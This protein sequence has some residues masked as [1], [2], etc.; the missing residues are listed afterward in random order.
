MIVIVVPRTFYLRTTDYGLRYVPRK[1]CPD[2]DTHWIPPN[3]K[4]LKQSSQL[5]PRTD[6]LTP[7][8]VYAYGNLDGTLRLY[9]TALRFAVR[10]SCLSSRNLLYHPRLSSILNPIYF[11]SVVCAPGR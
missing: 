8:R 10:L 3:G 11:L 5:I 1:V 7:P 6:A 9:Y 2:S 4:K